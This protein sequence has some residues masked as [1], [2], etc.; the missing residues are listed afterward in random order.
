MAHAV[1]HSAIGIKIGEVLLIM[2]LAARNTVNSNRGIKAGLLFLLFIIAS[3]PGF[4]DDTAE[5]HFT[6][7]VMLYERGEY[8][9]AVDAFEQAIKDGPSRSRYHH[10]LGKAY[11]RVAE[12]SGWFQAFGL[13]HRTRLA[14]ERAVELDENNREAIEDLMAFYKEAP[15]FVGGSPEK[16]ESL[17]ALLAGIDGD[18]DGARTRM[19]DT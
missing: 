13:A 9:A 11:G 10:W 5:H 15:A 12:Q 19:D 8:E 1:S 7:G 14:F 17:R 16:A 18:A 2:L 4:A 3:G 6:R